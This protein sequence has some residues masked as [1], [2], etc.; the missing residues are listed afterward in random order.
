MVSLLLQAPY[1]PP[2]C[3][4]GVAAILERLGQDTV[5]VRGPNRGVLAQETGPGAFLTARS[6]NSLA[7]PAWLQNLEEKFAKH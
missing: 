4:W 7:L 2:L 1:Q 3:V 5:F 6:H